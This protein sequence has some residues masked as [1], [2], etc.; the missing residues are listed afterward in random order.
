MFVKPG[1]YEELL[2]YYSDPISAIELLKLYR[3]YLETVPSMRRSQ[4]SLITIPLPIVHV[5]QELAHSVGGK[6]SV[7]DQLVA[8]P[9]DLVFLMCDPEWKIKMGVE[10]IVFIHRPDEDF[11]QLLGRW[12]QT[13]ILLS[14]SYSWEMP[15]GYKH[16]FSEGAE[17]KLPLF[18]LFE[19]TAERVKRGL[20]GA[21][22]PFVVQAFDMASENHDT[23][24]TELAD[25]KVNSSQETGYEF[26][27]E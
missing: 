13:Q 22:L 4:E 25:L 18:V 20:K 5:R 2:T 24:D 16:I 15:I 7:S 19:E 1:Q 11:S 21:Y 9:C 27:F 6:V 17:K 8:L 23:P 10:I 3:P 26:G 12:R 14:C